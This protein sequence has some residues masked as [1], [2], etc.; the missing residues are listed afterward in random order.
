MTLALILWQ[1]VLTLLILGVAVMLLALAR[2]IGVLHERMAPIGPQEARPGLDVGQVVPR[3]VLHTLEDRP[4]VI[5]EALQAGHR[6]M[7][8]FVAPEC[9]VCKRVI[10]IA[11]DVATA[12]GFEL[13]FVGDGPVPELKDMVASR[14]EMQGIPLLTGVE[15]GLVLQINRLPALVL[16]DE[17]GTIRVKDIVNTRRQIEDL[18]DTVPEAPRPAHVETGVISHAAV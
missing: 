3:L 5:G 17:R 9:P 11:R 8:L 6:Q 12:R 10:P 7:L 13:L 18:L 1:I 4:V 14:P 2:Q 15:L 16:L